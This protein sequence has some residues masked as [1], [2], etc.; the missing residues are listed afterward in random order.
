[1]SNSMTPWT[2]AHQ[3]ALSVG[4]SRQELEWIAVAFSRG[5]SWPS[6]WTQVSHIASI[7]L[8]FIYIVLSVYLYL[9]IHTHICIYTSMKQ[10]KWNLMCNRTL[11]Q[12]RL[13]LER[14]RWIW[15]HSLCLSAK[16]SLFQSLRIHSSEPTEMV[17]VVAEHIFSGGG[18]T[19]NTS[20]YDSFIYE[21]CKKIL[22][23]HGR[24]VGNFKLGSQRR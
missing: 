7:S 12:Y 20:K 4:F 6:Y 17:P 21:H 1:M 5:S 22:V 18:K 16:Y 11:S 10:L 15:M 8:S 24:E 23:K 14:V 19:D 3:A 2:V 13:L 9:S